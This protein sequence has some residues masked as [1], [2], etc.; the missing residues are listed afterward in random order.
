MRPE[1]TTG[2]LSNPSSQPAWRNFSP[3]GGDFLPAI[4]YSR[5]ALLFL[6]ST[7]IEQPLPQS[8]KTVQA[9]E[10]SNEL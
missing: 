9:V 1:G 10:I 4:I 6:N 7:T 3:I 5:A 8:T 2:A